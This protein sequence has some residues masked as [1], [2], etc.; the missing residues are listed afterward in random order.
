MT[1]RR[2]LSIFLVLGVIIS[3]FGCTPNQNEPGATP[4]D[5]ESGTE[6]GD[7]SLRVNEK[8]LELLAASENQKIT[9]FA[10]C[11][12]D[13]IHYDS[14]FGAKLTFEK[15][16]VNVNTVYDQAVWKENTKIE[17]A[18]DILYTI[19]GLEQQEEAYAEL[20]AVLNP[21]LSAPEY[22]EIRSTE[23]GRVYGLVSLENTVYVILFH[24]GYALRIASY[25]FE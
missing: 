6:S 24:G 21:L 9:F 3:L 15:G 19:E 13:P 2:I 12:L 16:I 20:M 22:Y 11:F 23:S 10:D 4:T 17:L 18:Q 14:V 25:T 7:D 5:S 8:L 1:V